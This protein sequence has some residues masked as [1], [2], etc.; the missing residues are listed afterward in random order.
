MDADKVFMQ[1]I[2]ELSEALALEKLKSNAFLLELNQLKAEK[3]SEEN[4]EKESESKG[5]DE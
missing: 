2:K 4:A 1:T 5:E 3:E